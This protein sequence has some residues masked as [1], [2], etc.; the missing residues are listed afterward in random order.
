M[1]KTKWKTEGGGTGRT[2][3]TAIGEDNVRFVRIH[4]FITVQSNT[5]PNKTVYCACVNN[6]GIITELHVRKEIRFENQ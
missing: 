3:T 6:I 1:W 4:D 2:G 5:E